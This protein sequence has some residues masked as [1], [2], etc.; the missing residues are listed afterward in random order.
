[1]H[2]MK[3]LIVEDDRTKRVTLSADISD[4]GYQVSAV[5]DAHKAFDLLEKEFIDVVIVDLRL[6]G[7]DG[8]ELL[9]LIKTEVSP[10]T[11]VIII[12]GYGSIPLAVESMRKGALDFVAKPFDNRHIIP[13][14]KGLEKKNVSEDTCRKIKPIKEHPE[15]EQIVVGRS[16]QIRMLRRLM[17]TCAESDAQVLL[18]GET[19]TGKD[20]VASVIHKHSRR[21]SMPFVKVSCAVFSEQLIESELFGHERGSFPGADQKKSGRL[22][23][24]EHGTLYLDDVDAIPPKVQVK[25]LR[26]IEENVF[27]RVGS[28]TP[29][30]CDV[31]IIASTKIDLAER[32]AQG[33]FREDLFYRLKV[34]ENKIPPLRERLEDIPLLAAH[35]LERISNSKQIEIPDK[36]ITRLN[37]YYWPGNVRELAYMLERAY[38]TGQGKLH[39]DQFNFAK[40]TKH[41]AK[42]PADMK[43]IV[44]QTERELIEASLEKADG[45]KNH[46]ARNL[47]M[48]P[49]TFRDKLSKYG[50]I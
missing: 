26:V 3:V 48:K 29:T 15:I 36:V 34:C 14:L 46:A 19:G 33:A 5:E 17:M 9:R 38:I 8:L 27:E 50:I 37:N 25:L 28:T 49:S 13:M 44:E 31:R 10:S 42:L 24:S 23:L 16:P 39:I 21:S 2:E 47:G 4:A 45:N 20:L 40:G 30:N 7:M 6:P 12:T 11:E 18:T 41:A 1:L 43:S 22:E 32:I 35:L